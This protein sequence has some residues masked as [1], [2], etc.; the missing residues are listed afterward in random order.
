MLH[1]LPCLC[2]IHQIAQPLRIQLII[3]WRDDITV[4]SI[5]NHIAC[6]RIR[7]IYHRHTTTLH[8]LDDNHRSALIYG[9]H[10]H[11]ARPFI[12]GLWTDITFKPYTTNAFVLYYF[13]EIRTGWSIT[14][15]RQYPAWVLRLNF[16][17]YPQQV[18]NFFWGKI[19]P[20]YR[21]H[22]LLFGKRLVR[23]NKCVWIVDGTQTCGLF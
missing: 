22:H 18:V 9:S 5:I 19:Q 15:N 23:R 11:D 1:L 8:G 13:L 3:K 7:V 21:K 2:I 14:A 12:K 6:C 4:L 20:A 17:P 10:A 16:L